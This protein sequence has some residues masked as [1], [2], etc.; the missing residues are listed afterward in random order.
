M[1]KSLARTSTDRALWDRG[2]NRFQR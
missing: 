2:V 1:S